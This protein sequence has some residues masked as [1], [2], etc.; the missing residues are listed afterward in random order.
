MD[1]FLYCLYLFN[2][3]IYISMQ[4]ALMA[5][6]EERGMGGVVCAKPAV[7]HRQAEAQGAG[8]EPTCGTKAY[9]LVSLPIDGSCNAVEHESL[10]PGP[11]SE[12]R[13][14]PLARSARSCAGL[15]L[16]R[17][18]RRGMGCVVG[19]V[20]A[21]MVSQSMARCLAGI[22]VGWSA[23]LCFMTIHGSGVGRGA[24][25]VAHAASS[26]GMTGTAGGGDHSGDGGAATA[27]AACAHVVSV[28][29]CRV[30]AMGWRGGD[31][32][33]CG[34]VVHVMVHC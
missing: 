12:V 3:Y 17:H 15:R 22:L 31:L 1:R 29:I 8:R 28:G 9:G 16:H 23:S 25:I 19:Q 34:S 18:P 2:D 26:L 5:K 11:G 32:G 14:T 21:D 33:H 7:E 4:L 13:D 27:A 24:R 6:Q 30:A 10:G 20:A